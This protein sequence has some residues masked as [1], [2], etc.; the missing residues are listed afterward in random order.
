VGG[1][2]GTGADA[3]LGTYSI[4]FFMILFIHGED[5]FLVNR[6][7]LALQKAFMQK[8]P[9]ADIFTFDFEDQGTLED[10]QRA[11]SACEGGLFSARKMVIFFHPFELDETSEKFLLAFL[12]N[13]AR[14]EAKEIMLLF[15]HPEKIKKTHKLARFLEK[16]NDKEEVFEKLQEKNATAFIKRELELIDD[17]AN[18]SPSALRMFSESLGNDTARIIT[19]LEKLAVFKPEGVF[20][21]D[22]V[23]LLTGIAADK[24]IFSALD[25]L[26]RDDKKCA[27]LLLRREADSLEN[28]LKTL[29]MCAWQTRRL[30]IVREAFDRGIQGVQAIATQTKLPSFVVQKMF[31]AIKNFPLSRIKRGLSMLSDFDTELKRGGMDPSV[32][33]DLFVWKF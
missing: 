12:D 25:A 2:I 17:K 4:G 22:D 9:D 5:G 13:F 32:A 27:L 11:L 14:K 31:G 26:S 24:N 30:L 18:F 16:H 7:R 28:T 23:L 6:R 21:E 20:E 3:S 19:E 15:V 10:V 8:Y 1:D 33:L 29:A